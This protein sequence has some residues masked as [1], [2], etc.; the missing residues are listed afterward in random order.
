MNSIQ[1][2]SLGPARARG[3]A[4][5]NLEEKRSAVGDLPREGLVLDDNI[6]FEA[7]KANASLRSVG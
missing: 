7:I 6:V 2:H 4:G 3:L 1:G 5:A